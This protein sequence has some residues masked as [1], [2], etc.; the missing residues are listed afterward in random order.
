MGRDSHPSSIACLHWTSWRDRLNRYS[1]HLKSFHPGPFRIAR[2]RNPSL[3]SS[4]QRQLKTDMFDILC[5][6]A[7]F[8]VDNKRREI[9][10][11]VNQLCPTTSHSIFVH[12]ITKEW[13]KNWAKHNSPSPE[14]IANCKSHS[15]TDRSQEPTGSWQVY[16]PRRLRTVYLFALISSHSAHFRHCFQTLQALKLLVRC[17]MIRCL[18]QLLW[19]KVT[20]WCH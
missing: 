20:S 6:W 19:N 12:M 2:Y 18:L 1:T 14:L 9:G 5:K 15:Q 13:G 8:R 7:C 10:W 17:E 4:S 16:W 3:M 11:K